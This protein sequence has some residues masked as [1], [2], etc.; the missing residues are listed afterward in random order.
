MKHTF[1]LE[2]GIWSATGLYSDEK[3]SQIEVKAETICKHFKDKWVNEGIMKLEVEEGSVVEIRND[4]KIEPFTPN[5]EYTSWTSVNPSLGE[6]KGL[7]IIVEDMILSKY[8]SNDGGYQGMESLY[9]Q[10]INTYINRGALF[11][12]YVKV[13]SWA[14]TLK[15]K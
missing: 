1:L 8:N 7:F 14:V 15:R 3:G 10:D 13:S 2:E 11:K 9:M 12:D 6:L 5:R 4:Y